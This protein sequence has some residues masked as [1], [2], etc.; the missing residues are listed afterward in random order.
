MNRKAIQYI[1]NKDV[2]NITVK[3]LKRYSPDRNVTFSKEEKKVIG[4]DI[5]EIAARELL[6]HYPTVFKEVDLDVEDKLYVYEVLS[7]VKEDLLEQ[8][9]SSDKVWQTAKEIFKPEDVPM[10]EEEGPPDFVQIKNPK[11]NKWVK[12]NRTTGI[13]VATRKRFGPFPDVPQLD[14]F[15]EEEEKTE[16]K[17]SE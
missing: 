12:I 13:I 17:E 9:V 14:I 16:E 5:S 4:D 8:G 1:G 3:S 6:K 11:T 15:A 10:E 7:C 2:A